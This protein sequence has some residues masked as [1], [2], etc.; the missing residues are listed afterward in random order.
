MKCLL[1]ISGFFI[2]GCSSVP[3]IIEIPVITEVKVYVTVP[4]PA[5]L[6]EPCTVDLSELNNNQDLERTLGAAI[7]E[8]RQCTADK[9]AISELE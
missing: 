3:A 5:T 4:V 7:L 8:L 1:L 2:L 6:L 9:V